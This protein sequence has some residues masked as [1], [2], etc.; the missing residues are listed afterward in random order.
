MDKAKRAVDKAAWAAK[1]VQMDEALVVSKRAAGRPAA[2]LCATCGEVKDLKPSGGTGYGI[3]APGDEAPLIECYA[4]CGLRDRADMLAHDTWTGY[5]KLPE[6]GAPGW[7][8]NWTGDFKLP[9]RWWQ[10]EKHNLWACP[11]RVRVWFAD[12]EGKP[13][14]GLQIGDNEIVRCRR[15]KR[16]PSFMR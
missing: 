15:I 1:Q 4:C 8:G 9:M 7:V 11:T 12:S 10:T 5:L 14:M 2:F 13:W 16:A 6:S 3:W